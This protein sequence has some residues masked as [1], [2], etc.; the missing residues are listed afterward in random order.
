[1]QAEYEKRTSNPQE[2]GQIDGETKE[3][4][5]DE[6][7]AESGISSIELVQLWEALGAGHKDLSCSIEKK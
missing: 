2:A 6:L 7:D 4:P 5:F 1:M 3:A